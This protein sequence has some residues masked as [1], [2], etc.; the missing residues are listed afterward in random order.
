M[1][2]SIKEVM[3][4]L[5]NVQGLGLLISDA[6][7]NRVINRKTRTKR[8]KTMSKE[9]LADLEKPFKFNNTLYYPLITKLDDC[10]HNNYMIGG[11]K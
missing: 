7:A 9:K 2:A 4:E 3:C 10:H 5:K 1:K 8:G 11:T 6:D